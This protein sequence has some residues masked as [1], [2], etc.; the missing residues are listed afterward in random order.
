MVVTLDGEKCIGCGVCTQIAP[1]IFA[2]DE[3]RGV[4]KVVR[5]EGG[6]S[7]EQAV[8]SCPV[9]CIGYRED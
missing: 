2:L 9:S 3:E 8:E 6:K 1:D 7:V 4:A 5:N